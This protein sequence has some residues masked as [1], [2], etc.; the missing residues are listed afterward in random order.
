MPKI[1]KKAIEY[2]DNLPIYKNAYATS[3]AIGIHLDEAMEYSQNKSFK[4]QYEEIVNKRKKQECVEQL[5]TIRK[6]IEK[7]SYCNSCRWKTNGLDICCLPV[8]MKRK[9]CVL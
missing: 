2:F 8:C 3:K 7:S 4:T 1:P 6:N 5:V 9:D